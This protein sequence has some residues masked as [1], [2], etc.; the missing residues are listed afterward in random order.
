MNV[1]KPLGG[2]QRA[3]LQVNVLEWVLLAILVASTW[4]YFWL[5]DDAFIYFRYIDNLLFLDRGLVYNQ[6]EYVEGYTGPAWL[7]FLIPFRMLRLDYWTIVRSL[8][9]AIAFIF[10][11]LLIRLNRDLSPR[12]ARIVNLPLAIAAGHY[13]IVAHFSSGLET[14][15]VQLW[16][17]LLALWTVRPQSVALQA[18][19]GLTPLI[20]P[21]LALPAL[22]CAG[23]AWI[24]SRRFP[25]AY[26]VCTGVFVG[27]WLV[28]RVYYYADL[29]PNTY[30][31]KGQTDWSQGLWYL[32]SGVVWQWWVWLL[33]ACWAVVFVLN[34]AGDSDNQLSSAVMIVA[35]GSVLI[36]V[37]RIGGDMTYHRF[38]ACPTTLLLCS[39]AGGAETL[40]A[41]IKQ[42]RL[43]SVFAVLLLVG[44]WGLSLASYPPTLAS[45]PL[46]HPQVVHW[47]EIAEGQWHRQ[48]ED[49]APSPQRPLQ[50]QQLL[51][52]YADI[53]A[54]NAPQ[55]RV[56]VDGWCRNGFVAPSSYVIN[57]FGLTDAIL[58]RIDVGFF[59]PGH[60]SSSGAAHELAA[61]VRRS[62]GKREPGMFRRAVEAGRAPR[63]VKNSLSKI[64]IVE[65]KI[66]NRHRF[67]ENL[68]LALQSIGRIPM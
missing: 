46:T 1:S 40:I 60:K 37:A 12:G 20:R 68:H 39:V 42:T 54:K 18:L 3:F 52:T 50:D 26:L 51:A 21:E 56:L 7:L 17:L 41:R 13:G 48:H 14:P 16:S 35:A 44:A 5:M 22:I 38:L 63:W 4:H 15:L 29:L 36:W 34:N 2:Y 43:R 47:H 62:G 61:I 58:A 67:S 19:A 32:A 28:F 23:G 9:V 53:K 33:P 49:L 64:E 59:R 24:R 55:V 10:G 8:A 31:L 11:L 57:S 27:G 65:Q 30:Y 6:G 45:H 25:L 66:Y